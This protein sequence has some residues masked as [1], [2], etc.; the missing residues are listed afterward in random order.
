M[1]SLVFIRLLGVILCGGL[2]VAFAK[3]ARPNFVIFIT[4]DQSAIHREYTAKPLVMPM[5]FGFNG[6]PAYTPNI[7]RMSREGVR[8]DRA[9]VSTPVCSASRYSTL[10]GKYA[11]RCEGQW[12]QKLHPPGNMTRTENNTELSLDEDN[13]AKLLRGAGYRTGFVG[14]SHVVDHHI[15]N[16][17]NLWEDYGLQPYAKDADPRDPEID[18]R[19]KHNQKWWQQ[20]IAAYGFDEVA[21]VYAGNLRELFN[22]TLNVHNI[23][24]TTRAAR[25]FIA[26][27]DERPFFLY[28]ATTLPHGPDPWNQRNGKYFAGLDADPAITGEGLVEPDYG[29]MPGRQEIKKM[30]RVHRADVNH[31]YVTQIDAA[32][33]AIRDQLRATGQL[34]NTVFIFKSDHGAWR[35]G[36]STLYEGGVKIPLVMDWP[37]GAKKGVV[38]DR[39]VQNVDLMPTLLELAGAD[40]PKG[41]VQ[42]GVSLAPFLRGEGEIPLRDALFLEIGYSRGVVTPK[43]KYIAVR[44]TPEVEAKIRAGETWSGFKGDRLTRPY[45]VRNEHLGHNSSRHNPNYFQKDQLYDLQA[46]PEELHNVADQYPGI[47]RQMQ[48]KLQEFLL[49]FPERPFGDLTPDFYQ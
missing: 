36:K 43:W 8:F 19:M 1:R 30:A 32:V 48:Q 38:V 3:D 26:R 34:D 44:Y 21:S 27:K 7:D 15:L 45:L 33:G 20:R 46:D 11:G 29:F 39:L 47:T 17:P 31:A 4:D 9:Y 41:L 13:V 40:T 14:K 42:D 5:S 37:A 28:V 10:T 6:A 49:T 23:E 22:N 16:H 18:A 35:Y 24:W 12:Y 2:P 25:E